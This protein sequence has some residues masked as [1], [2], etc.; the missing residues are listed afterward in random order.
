MA[1]RGEAGD[2]PA[3]PRA[4]EPEAR[5]AEQDQALAWLSVC[6]PCAGGADTPVRS[7]PARS[8]VEPAAPCAPSENG[9]RRSLT[10]AP[11][12]NGLRGSPMRAPSVNGSRLPLCRL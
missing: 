11:S 4:R 7:R 10:R 2:L 9:S 1:L 8:R 6:A 3:R 12:V 5:P